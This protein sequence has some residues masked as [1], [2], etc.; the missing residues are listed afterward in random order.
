MTRSAKNTLKVLFIRTIRFFETSSLPL[1]NIMQYI[2]T[3]NRSENRPKF[4]KLI[5]WALHH[6]ELIDVMK[7]SEYEKTKASSST[8]NL[9]SSFF[10]ALTRYDVSDSTQ[11]IFGGSPLVIYENFEAYVHTVDLNTPPFFCA[12]CNQRNRVIASSLSSSLVCTWD[13][14][15]SFHQSRLAQPDILSFSSFECGK[16]G[17]LVCISSNRLSK[18]GTRSSIARLVPGS[19]NTRST[20]VWCGC[21]NGRELVSCPCAQ[22]RKT[23]NSMRKTPKT[24]RTIIFHS[25]HF[26]QEASRIDLPRQQAS[27]PSWRNFW[28]RGP[29]PHFCQ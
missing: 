15:S 22:T 25:C 21:A 19:R 4:F 18:E 29:T 24:M 8:K 11:V 7:L 3:L 5:A 9:L 26:L 17:I 27:P 16:P 20:P 23:P 12:R 6:Y 28:R 1:S 13:T 14:W 10:L 2:E